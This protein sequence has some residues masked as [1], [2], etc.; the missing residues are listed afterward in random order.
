[1][2]LD[3][4]ERLQGAMS[5]FR[6]ILGYQVVMLIYSL[7][8][9]GPINATTVSYAVTIAYWY[10]LGHSLSRID[11]PYN[12]TSMWSKGYIFCAVL[13]LITDA[14]TM[15]G[16]AAFLSLKAMPSIVLVLRAILLLISMIEAQETI[17]KTDDGIFEWAFN[18]TILYPC[19]ELGRFYPWLKGST[20]DSIP[21]SSTVLPVRSAS[22]FDGVGHRLGGSTSHPTNPWKVQRNKDGKLQSN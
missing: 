5:R 18:Y 21:Q 12:D 3:F 1:M 20:S 7:T 6:T 2:T 4:G 11:D 9:L 14:M 22:G 17:S 10:Q 19:Q 15:G 8:V 16:W 13:V